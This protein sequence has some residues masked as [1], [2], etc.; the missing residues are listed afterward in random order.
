L[1]FS[2]HGSKYS[3]KSARLEH[4]EVIHLGSVPECALDVPW[5]PLE[6]FDDVLS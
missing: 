1:Q 4:V 6:T 3:I 2:E 5:L